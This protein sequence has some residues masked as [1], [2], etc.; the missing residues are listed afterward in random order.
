MKT[1]I[2]SASLANAANQGEGIAHLSPGQAWA[3]NKLKMPPNALADPLPSHTAAILDNIDRRERQRF[4]AAC[5]NP[6]AMIQAVYDER[7]PA[8]LRQ[9]V[10]EK[11]SEGMRH[12]F[13]DL[14]PAGIDTRTGKPVYHLSDLAKALDTTEDELDSLAAQHGMQNT[15]DDSDVTRIH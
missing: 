9:P 6:D 2:T 12:C 11:L 4:A 1:T 8:Y 13:P 10:L 15:I 5:P 3:A 7:H 14:K